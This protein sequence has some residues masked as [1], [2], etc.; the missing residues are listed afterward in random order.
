MLAHYLFVIP[1]GAFVH[2]RYRS[3]PFFTIIP[4]LVDNEVDF[5]YPYKST[6]FT[7]KGNIQIF[8][9]SVTA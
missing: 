1:A 7:L 5:N 2:Y 9:F 8:F 4:F 3:T 6:P